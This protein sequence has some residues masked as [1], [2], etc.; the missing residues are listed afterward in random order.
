MRERKEL[1]RL[2]SLPNATSVAAESLA[3][4]KRLRGSLLWDEDY[5]TLRNSCFIIVAWG[6]GRCFQRVSIR[7]I[8]YTLLLEY[9]QTKTMETFVIDTVA[10]PSFMSAF[11]Q[12]LDKIQVRKN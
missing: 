11:H 5:K 4:Q 9:R 10:V 12:F 7:Y 1:E 6:N 3:L 8:K 2:S